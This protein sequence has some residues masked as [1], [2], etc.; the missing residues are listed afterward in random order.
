MP[1]EDSTWIICIYPVKS[2][3]NMEHQ[4]ALKW[5]YVGFWKQCFSFWTDNF[6][7]L[8]HHTKIIKAL[9]L[10]PMAQLTW[11]GQGIFYPLPTPPTEQKNNGFKIIP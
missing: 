7:P 2:P 8:S 10:N 6:E 4:E 9:V 5:S 1:R 11:H 3:T